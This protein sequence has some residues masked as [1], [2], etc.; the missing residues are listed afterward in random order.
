MAIKKVLEN[1][2]IVEKAGSVSK[3][4]GMDSQFSAI[5]PDHFRA[6]SHNVLYQYNSRGFRDQ[7]W[8]S[9]QQLSSAVWCLGDS[10]T[11]GIGSPF[12]HTWPQRLQLI[13]GK[14]TI[15]VSMDGASN[16]WLAETCCQIYSEIK[17]QNIV[18]MWSFPHRR[19]APG[20]GTPYSRRLHYEK[21]TV[22]QDYENLLDC[23]SHVRNVCSDSNI[24]ELIVPNWQITLTQTSWDNISVCHWRDLT[25][26][27]WPSCV[28]E[29]DPG[30][31]DIINLLVSEY[32]IDRHSLLEQLTTQQKI[33]AWH[34]LIQVPL[35][36]RARD[37]H[38]F[39]IATANWIVAEIQH[40][41][42]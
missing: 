2:E 37:G 6:F 17:P 27:D 24:V 26:S 25:D 32:H 21:T 11:V 1:I 34:N 36:D 41:L 28:T 12:E 22:G 33:P 38:H 4:S 30:R 3:F 20:P 15:N 35:I 39:D 10:F 23:R 16:A 29:I 5:D 8:P 14:R 13:T 42:K 7:E 9:D 18:V 19:Q 40:L 31:L